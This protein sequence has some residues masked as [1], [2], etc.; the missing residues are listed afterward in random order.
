MADLAALLANLSSD[1][2]FGRQMIVSAHSVDGTGAYVNPLDVRAFMTEAAVLKMY[3]AWERYL[4][5][6]FLTYLM[7]S[8]STSGRAITS[9]LAAPSS[10]HANKVLIGTS[11][12]VDWGNPDIV[13]R[14]AGLY[15]GGGGPYKS[16][17]AA[18]QSDL[19]DLRAVR[20]AAAHLSSSTSA[21]LDAVG[22]RRLGHPVKGISVY[23]LVTGVDASTPGATVLEF[24]LAILSAAAVLISNG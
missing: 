15:F 22:L 18:V 11:K 2:D 20:N 3:I 16:G 1:F 12:Y 23:D 13:N 19:F 6:S 10:E 14:L 7:G 21:Q 4:E 8:L 5:Q 9:F 17:I 24:Y